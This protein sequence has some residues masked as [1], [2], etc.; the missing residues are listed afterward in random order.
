MIVPK[1]R[2]VVTTTSSLASSPIPVPVPAGG[3]LF[4][5]GMLP[6][7]TPTNLS[8]DRRRALQLHFHA[9]D[10]VVLDD[11]AYDALFTEADGTAASC[12]ANRER[13]F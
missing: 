4:F 3:G 10:A 8:D 13:G 2:L 7:R 5:Y 6:H 12:K 1:S 11:K 9:K